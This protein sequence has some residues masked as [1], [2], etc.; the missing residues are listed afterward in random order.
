MK[1]PAAGAAAGAA[2]DADIYVE[3]HEGVP[4]DEELIGEEEEFRLEKELEHIMFGD[5]DDVSGGHGGG[6]AGVGQPE[7]ADGASDHRMPESAD[8]P[9]FPFELVASPLTDGT[10]ADA[11]RADGPRNQEMLVHARNQQT[12]RHLP[13]Q[14]HHLSLVRV[15]GKDDET[16]VFIV[17]WED[18]DRRFE[19]FI[20]S[21]RYKISAVHTSSSP[22]SWH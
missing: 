4:D 21:S 18:V 20:N 9:Q 2:D 14:T 6:E 3:E 7:E 5:E 22:M 12:H 8:A 15:S 16:T 13:L 10:I 17:R 19:C 11:I 1:E